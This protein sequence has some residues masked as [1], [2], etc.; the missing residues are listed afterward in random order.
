MAQRGGTYHIDELGDGE[1]KAHQDHVRDVGDG[2]GPLVI[3]REEFLQEP[4]LGVGSGLHVSK[5]CGEAMKH[6]QAQGLAQLEPP[7]EGNS[8]KS[9]RWH[10]G[11]H[12]RVMLP[13]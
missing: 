8:S 10:L 9:Q 12:R 7:P 6:L 4:L 2:T 13:G 1:P 5:G 3:A 11:T